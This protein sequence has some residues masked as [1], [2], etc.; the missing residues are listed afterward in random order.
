MPWRGDLVTV[1]LALGEDRQDVVELLDLLHLDALQDAA[2]GGELGLPALDV[3]DVDRVRLGDEAVDRRR[4]VEVLHRHLEAEILRG[5]VAD[6][7]HDR[8][9]DADMAQ[10][11]VLDLLR[12]DGRE[13][14]NR[15]CSGGAARQR[16]ARFQQ[17]APRHAAPDAGAAVYR[18]AQRL[19][20]IC[21]VVCWD[22]IVIIHGNSPS[23]GAHEVHARS[24]QVVPGGMT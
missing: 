7:L 15:A 2:L 6:R 24:I 10:L 22:I 5:L 3:R 17:R 13:A 11:D 21:S 14:G 12:P 18:F 19:C 1:D 20:C 9:R 4:G 23:R 16:S 8:V